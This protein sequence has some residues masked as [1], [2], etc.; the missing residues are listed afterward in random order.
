ME[1]RITSR[2]NEKIKQLCKLRDSAAFR[3]A[4]QCFLAEGVRL[5]RDIAA[6]RKPREVYVT[7]KALAQH[8]ELAALPG[9]RILVSDGVAGKISDTKNPQ[10]VFC[11]FDCVLDSLESTAPA[12]RWLVLEH[13]QDPANIGALMRSAAAFGFDGVVLCADCA[14]PYSPKAVR[15]SMATVARLKLLQ[16]ETVQQVAAWLKEARV[17]LVAAAL[18]HSVPLD[19][20]DGLRGSNVALLI[21]NEGNGLSDAAV[22]AADVAVRIPMAP[23]VESLNAAVAGSVLLWHFRGV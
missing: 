8:P 13:V 18:Y 14:D 12:G 1:L 7:E 16:A 4:Q 20:A 15:A 19:E 21:G 2:E 3:Q 5:C 6:V 17:P 23:G 9:P 22:N 10:G 11:V